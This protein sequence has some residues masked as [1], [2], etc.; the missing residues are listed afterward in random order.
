LIL[1]L[2]PCEEQGE[3]LRIQKQIISPRAAR[4]QAQNVG[5]YNPDV[6]CRAFT[7]ERDYY[8]DGGKPRLLCFGLLIIAQV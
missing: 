8:P 1:F 5:T 3:L 7:A 6:L 2:E 4:Y